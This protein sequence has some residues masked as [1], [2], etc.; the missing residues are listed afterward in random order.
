MRHHLKFDP[1]GLLYV[2]VV[3][4]GGTGSHLV[5]LLTE[6]HKGIVALG[7]AG[8]HV[9]LYDDDE[10]SYTNTIRQNYGHQEIGRNKAVTLMT[11]VN[12][13]CS[14]TWTAV[15][16]RFT[17]AQLPASAQIYGPQ[18]PHVVFT[19]VD[20]NAARREIGE[21]F[22]QSRAG[23]WIDTGN[24]QA[25][26]QVILSEPRGVRGK[27]RLPTPL[28]EYGELLGIDEEDTPSC[29]ALE[30]LTRQDLMINREVAVKAVGLWWRLL[31]NGFVKHRG[32]I[33][34][35][36]EGFTMPKRIEEGMVPEY[37]TPPV[38]LIPADQ[39][40]EVPLDLLGSEA[41][42]GATPEAPAPAKPRKPR[43]KTG[44]RAPRRPRGAPAGETPA[45][46]TATP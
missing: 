36:D 24:A 32:L 13:A 41:G 8:L 5:T 33:I 42:A 16:A 2:A 20:T 3:G 26:G 22:V 45:V 11:R 10:V 40:Q 17:A 25:T 30:S 15:P 31:R 34:N 44:T 35:A 39:P 7:G 4:A 21:A 18:C 43:A 1:F 14:L 23:Y 37:A 6:V 27:P 19:C 12:L 9:T 28:E 38:G 29:S 46:T